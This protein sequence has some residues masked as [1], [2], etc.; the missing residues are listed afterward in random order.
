PGRAADLGLLPV[1]YA[2]AAGTDVICRGWPVVERQGRRARR[3]DSDRLGQGAVPVGLWRRLNRAEQ[4]R[5]AAGV[6]LGAGCGWRRRATG[7]PSIQTV[8]EVTVGDV[9]RGR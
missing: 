4:G 9:Q 7:R 2:G 5:A 6:D 8:L 1:V 3:R